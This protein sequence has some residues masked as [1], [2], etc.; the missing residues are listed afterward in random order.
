MKLFK[1]LLGSIKASRK[2][3][4][5]ILSNNNLGEAGAQEI[6]RFLQEDT[7]LLSLDVDE[8]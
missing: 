6:A 1:G 7:S 3:K 5:L 2:L 8:N 4:H